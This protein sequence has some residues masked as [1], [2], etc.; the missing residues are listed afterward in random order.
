MQLWSHYGSE[1]NEHLQ[2]KEVSFIIKPV[3]PQR[4][5]G[6]SSRALRD[7]D[8]AAKFM[9]QSPYLSLALGRLQLECWVGVAS[10]TVVR[11]PEGTASKEEWERRRKRMK[12]IKCQCLGS[13]W[14]NNGWW[15]TKPFPRLALV[16]VGL[17]LLNPSILGMEMVASGRLPRKESWPHRVR[18]FLSTFSSLF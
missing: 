3:G 4:R 8:K 7:K 17:V 14:P 11:H 10:S 15:A 2:A 18:A 12:F 1:P 16:E 9:V 6:E 5:L 13:F